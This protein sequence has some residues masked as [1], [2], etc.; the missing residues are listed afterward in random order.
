MRSCTSIPAIVAAL[1]CA[2]TRERA[3][4]TIEVRWS[5]DTRAEL[6][7]CGCRSRPLGGIARRATIFGAAGEAVLRLD[8]GNFAAGQEDYEVLA[9]D[10]MLAAYRAMGYDALNLARGETAF[11]AR[12]IRLIGEAAPLISANVEYADGASVAP[13]FRIFERGGARIAVIGLA[14]QA[15]VEGL[16]IGDPAL[17]L[18]RQLPAM[19]SKSDARI[20]L[21][22][23][24]IEAAD[25]IARKYPEID[26]ILLAGTG[27]PSRELRRV[28]RTSIAVLAGHGK[29]IAKTSFIIGPTGRVEGSE[30]HELIPLGPEIAADPDSAGIIRRFKDTIRSM[31]LTIDIPLPRATEARYAGARACEP[32]HSHAYRVWEGSKHPKALESLKA[33]GDDGDPR[34]LRCHVLALGE[35][36][37][38]QRRRPTPFRGVECESCHGR[39][40]DHVEA[41]RA[42]RS[43]PPLVRPT[44]A[45]CE[46]CHDGVQSDP[47]DMQK[48]WPP[49]DHREGE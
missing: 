26:L 46:G 33:T 14:A 28:N 5:A 25:G 21:A 11:G 39:A 43:A 32:C 45:D 47:F 19:I 17:A 1:L 35:E 30:S 36:D 15:D 6:E 42:G 20:L 10:A 44:A 41:H 31:R 3:P 49:I 8:A 29:I 9:L 24:D 48:Y 37:G 7:A 16:R 27:E 2:C 4:A 13:P 23:L 40:S 12:G 18:A 22:D 38:Y 34:C